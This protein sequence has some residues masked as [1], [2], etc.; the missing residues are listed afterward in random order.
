VQV[1]NGWFPG[2][3]SLNRH[4]GRLWRSGFPVRKS[5][6][7]LR[8]SWSVSSHNRIVGPTAGTGSGGKQ[9]ERYDCN[10]FD[11][12]RVFDAVGCTASLASQPTVGILSEWW[13][14]V[15]PRDSGHPAA[16]GPAL[17]RRTGHAEDGKKCS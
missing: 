13:P 15:G 8:M 14:R 7:D 4:P 1:T 10:C 9:E 2:R 3:A 6:T 12:G 17:S 5:W 16:S 11:R